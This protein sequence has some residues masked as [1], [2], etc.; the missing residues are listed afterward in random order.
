M[1]NA[2][3]PPRAELPSTAQ[4]VKSTV[5]AALA[6]VAILVTIV[7][8]AEYAIDPTGIGRAL[9]LTDMGAIKKQLAIEAEADRR[10]QSA[11]AQPDRRS[12]LPA[13]VVGLLVSPA[14]AHPNHDSDDE[15][16]PQPTPSGAVA[17][18]APAAKSDETMITLK[19]GE[20]VEYK[21]TMQSGAKVQY[22]WKTDGGK[23]NYDMHGTSKTGG[24]ETSYRKGSG[25]AS[26]T[27]VLTAGS[28]GGH[29]WFWRNRGSGDV[30]IILK[31]SGD[32]SDIRKMK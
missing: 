23:V 8:P 2:E 21:L 3:I 1:F 19:S 29:G 32:Y 7:L 15:V 11:P 12:S 9:Q 6:A 14:A 22:S 4:L 25:V 10:Q 18:A 30:T 16:A 28:D 20:G 26:D 24:K 5:I 27:G 17:Q 31:T 13:L